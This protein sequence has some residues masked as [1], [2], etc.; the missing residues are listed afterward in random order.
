MEGRAGRGTT[1]ASLPAMK[2][3]LLLLS[4]TAVGCAV[5]LALL[6]R[7]A[8][9]IRRGP[10]MA[11]PERIAAPARAVIATKMGR[12]AEQLSTLVT[13]V[14][15]LDYE[16]VARTAGEIFDEPGLARPISG[17]EL[18]GLLPERFFVL[19]DALRAHAKQVVA[20]AAQHDGAHLADVFGELTKT[21]VACH[22][23][24]LQGEPR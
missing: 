7:P 21:C 16:G 13:E 14:V 11:R 23:V 18:N 10:E 6:L 4:S 22:A 17:D 5:A 1:L 12:H 9:S 8:H 3:R 20:A 15:V 19:Q 2:M 24:Y